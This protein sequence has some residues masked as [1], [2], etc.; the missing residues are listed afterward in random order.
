MELG[1]LVA[2]R[3]RLEQRVGSGGMG[4]V[5]RAIDEET[6]ETVAL[7]VLH[8]TLPESVERFG[9]EVAA[10]ARMSHPGIVRY[11]A[12]GDSPAFVAMEWLE[13][14][15]LA[16]RLRSG[17]MEIADAIELG[18]RLA[19]ALEHAHGHGI[20]HRDIK[21][22]NIL[23]ADGRVRIVDFGLAWIAG[24]VG[25]RTTAGTMLG[26]PGYMAP[27]QARGEAVDARADV[28]ALSCVLYKCLTGRGPFA[29]GDAVATLA[30]MLFDEAEPAS[31]LRP[32]VPTAL[33]A[34]LARGMAK[35]KIRRP[36]SARAFGEELRRIARGAE[37][38]VP[39][40]PPAPS[41]TTVLTDRERRIV[42]VVVAA[43]EALGG[44]GDEGDTLRAE[45]DSG[46]AAR[47]AVLHEI[48][49]RHGA[50]I[51]VLPVAI[52]ALLSGV[53]ASPTG[54]GSATDGAA[55]AARL[56]L[57]L[58]D[59]IGDVPIAL[60]TGRAEI[61]GRG[62]VAIG[63]VIDRAVARVVTKEETGATRHVWI[64]ETTAG[65]L[66][67]SFVVHAAAGGLELAGER[68]ADMQ[69]R[70]LL[71][72]P[73]PCVGRDRELAF[74]DATL[75]ECESDEVARAVI[76]T[77][78]AGVG[79]SRVRYEWLRKL[80][81]RH[82]PAEVWSARADAMTAG[83]PFSLVGQLVRRAAGIDPREP[84]D[85]ARARLRAR[86]SR[87]VADETQVLRIAEFLGETVG[88]R[89]DDDDRV[90]LR[91]ARRDPLLMG[92]Q[93][94]R[95]FE[96]WIGAEAAAAPLVIVLEDLHWGDLPSVQLV[97]WALGA[98][99]DAPLMVVALARPEVKDAFPN[100]W[101]ARAPLELAIGELTPKAGARLARHVLGTGAP[102]DVVERAVA[103]AA[104]NAFF[105]EEILRATSEGHGD[106][107]PETVLAMVQRRLDALEP[108]ARRVLRAASVFGETFWRGAVV[109]HAAEGSNP[110]SRPSDWIRELMT[111]E[112]VTARDSSRFPGEEELL[113][114]HAIVREAAY[115]MLTDDDR[116]L[117]HR[118]AGAWLEEHGERDAAVL[119]EHFDRGG[120][121][122][123][124]VAHYAR[125]A[126]Q[127][128]E[129]NDLARV[130]D[131]A[132]RGVTLGASGPILGELRRLQCE[133][134]RW[135]GR[136][137]EAETCAR[138]ATVL[139]EPATRSW[140]AAIGELATSSG[141]LGHVDALLAAHADVVARG[142]ATDADLPVALARTIMQLFAVGKRE[143]ADEALAELDAFDA[144]P[145]PIVRARVE[146]ARAISALYSSDH[147]TYY[148]KMKSVRALFEAAGDRRNACVQAAN[149]GYVA[150][151]LGILDEAEETL[152]SMMAVTDALGIMR[153]KAI[154]QQNTALLRHLQGRHV[155]AVALAKQSAAT[156]DAQG[157]ARL[158]AFSRIYGSMALSASGAAD[159]A[160][161]EAERAVETSKPLAPAYASAL[162][163]LADLE[164]RHGRDA[165]DA[166]ARASEA[167]AI[168]EKLGGIEDTESLV[169]V[170]YAEALAAVGRRDEAAGVLHKAVA[171][172][173]ERAAKFRSERFRESFKRTAENV[174]TYALLAKLTA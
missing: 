65:L 63:E 28:F 100:L 143:L 21:P 110:I 5:Y 49:K 101:Q 165:K 99:A 91:A 108:D 74:L 56:S 155:E 147:G 109:A 112:L 6:R 67:P 77:G 145:D 20:V 159:D 141:A 75:A 106:D 114:R 88:A 160:I 11:V 1:Q 102:P 8:E 3:F 76:L 32:G 64:D 51:E 55:A 98:H 167:Y 9:R 130:L 140:Y 96:D 120:E 40:P 78:P 31:S 18:V 105:L 144:S 158:G 54:R 126:A 171:G 164:L 48:A 119:A 148:E 61:R 66:G 72:K 7:K 174:R 19:D 80:A 70:T 23:F 29:G 135:R 12:H 115:A 154:F 68:Q 34:L 116:A 79:K 38:A 94:R 89:F 173:E 37:A 17:P 52:V 153:I 122:T 2:G 134:L 103:R 136:I 50:R 82:A 83:A 150:V 162:A 142:R 137:A 73:T 129:G 87:H 15:D 35:E 27:E 149:M 138:E 13:G 111:R 86:I 128:L 36:V 92:D 33:D 39:A 62:G 161:A 166:L 95:A 81:E 118:L 59:A 133:A 152:T 172:I 26:T 124:A 121:K 97:D 42:S 45:I 43:R 41:S 85:A 131:R 16:Q 117:A 156:F 60:A 53:S 157:D 107:V 69:V 25:F 71:G 146:Q 44:S 22:G 4:T 123:R 93:I 169:R 57:A 127:A 10:L 151:A 24:D 104:G 163:N 168:L 58:R 47:E 84:L 139:L 125:A 132:E 170:A 113:F 30:K 90:Q 46:F 14:E